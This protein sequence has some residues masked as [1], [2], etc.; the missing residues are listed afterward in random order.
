MGLALARYAGLRTPSETLVLKWE[1]VDL[2]AGRMTINA[3][4]TEHH[5]SGGRRV[6]P[7][8]RELRPYREAVCT[9][10]ARDATHVITR[11]RSAKQNLRTH[12]E[13]IIQHAGQEPWP[14]LF[15]NLRASC[16]TELL[17]VYPAKDVASWLGNSVPVAMA[18]YA[19]AR[20][21]VSERAIAEGFEWGRKNCKAE[22]QQNAQHSRATGPDP[23]E[24][25][26][27]DGTKKA[28]ENP[29]LEELRSLATA[30]DCGAK[31][32][33]NGTEWAIQNS[34]L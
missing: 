8:F 1:D 4:K 10:N 3:S 30:A 16:E 6:C 2:A 33:D 31:G 13:K 34:N 9:A 7:V 24:S 12:F 5:R 23:E 29:G 25:P 20:Q 22:A 27:D 32:A 17:G 18:H 14:K 19:M 26:A 28:P 21:D 11:Y 15:Q